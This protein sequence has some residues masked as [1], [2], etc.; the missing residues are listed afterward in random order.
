LYAVFRAPSAEVLFA[1]A[2]RLME[3]KTQDAAAQAR[4]GPIKDYLDNY[5]DRTDAQAR[6]IREWADRYD[7]ALR[8]LQMDKRQRLKLSPDGEAETQA[9]RA[10]HCEEDGDWG[11]AQ[12]QWRQV[13]KF[14]AEADADLRV[15]GL[16]AEKRLQELATAAAFERELM[17]QVSTYSINLDAFKANPIR[18]AQQAAAAASGLD[19]KSVLDQ[20]VRATRYELFGDHAAARANWQAVKARCE[21]EMEQRAWFLLAAKRF[22]ELSATMPAVTK[23][24]E[25]KA[26][27]QR[28]KEALDEARRL[29]AEKQPLARRQAGR[30]CA[31][32][33]DLYHEFPD[34]RDSPE[35]GLKELV[36][37][38]QQLSDQLARQPEH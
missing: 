26:R 7:V 28:I 37:Q 2:Q 8:E 36:E 18:N 14:K 5:G 9:R 6:Q 21:T 35:P 29:V 34:F 25:T 20:A 11:G 4:N 31:D 19:V 32:I 12:E 23:E 30:I 38:A 1:Q 3:A 22:H 33:F 16:L 27:L 10:V 17:T 15:W 13:E 24:E